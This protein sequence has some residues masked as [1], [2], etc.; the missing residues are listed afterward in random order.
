MCSSDLFDGNGKLHAR[1]CGV[2]CHVGVLADIR[3]IG[4]G[5]TPYCLP[6]EGITRASLSKMYEDAHLAERPGSNCPIVTDS[7]ET[8]AAILRGAHSKVPLYISVGHRVS[9]ASALSLIHR[10]TKNAH[11]PEPVRQA[12]LRGRAYVRRYVEEQKKSH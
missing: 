4:V 2:A 3:S 8:V 9:L 5:K 12:D 7:G 10:L 1:R 6:D 11:I